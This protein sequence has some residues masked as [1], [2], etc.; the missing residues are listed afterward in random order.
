MCSLER[1]DRNTYPGPALVWE[2]ARPV[3]E[4]GGKIWLSGDFQFRETTF[5]TAGKKGKS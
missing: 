1:T 5:G 3:K 2:A 4:E